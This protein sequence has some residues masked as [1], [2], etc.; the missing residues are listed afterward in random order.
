MLTASWLVL[1]LCNPSALGRLHSLCS[2]CWNCSSLLNLAQL[3]K[4]TFKASCHE[5]A[6]HQTLSHS[7]ARIIFIAGQKSAFISVFFIA[8]W[9]TFS[10]N[11]IFLWEFTGCIVLVSQKCNCST[12][13][14]LCLL[15]ILWL[16]LKTTDYLLFFILT[17][18]IR[19]LLFDFS[20]NQVCYLGGQAIIPDPDE[21]GPLGLP[22]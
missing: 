16:N 3:F 11:L 22:L 5:K 18:L 9:H 15:Q 10:N 6:N 2:G 12:Q 21:R 17:I 4:L 7:H 20:L 13:K 8:L 1:F 14:L 19:S